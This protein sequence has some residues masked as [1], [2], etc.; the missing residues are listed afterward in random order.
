MFK[1]VLLVEDEALIALSEA[2]ILK[3]H[4]FE[5]E[6][7]YNGQQ[8]VDK[9][10]ADS[11]IT[12]VLMDIDLGQGMNGAE[13]AQEILRTQDIPIVFLT[14]HTEKEYVDRV[15]KITGYGYILKNSGEM[16]L[17]SSINMAY[18]LYAAHQGLKEQQS[19]NRTLIDSA[20]EGKAVLKSFLNQIPGAA[21]VKDAEN[22]IVFC[23]KLFASIL[24]DSPQNLE[25]KNISSAVPQATE[26]KYE[27]ENRAV[28]ESGRIIQAESEFP[29]NGE[30]TFWL[31]YKF[32][33][34]FGGRTMVGA[35]SIDLTAQKQMER[36][37]RTR[38]QHFR[39]IA[40]YTYA[41]EDWIGT[42]GE[43]IWV[44]PAVER[45]TG[46]TPEEC[47][48]MQNYPQSLIHPE[49]RSESLQEIHEGLAQETSCNDRELRCLC[50]D[51]STK[52]ISVSWQPIY[53]DEGRHIGTRSSMR[54]ITENKATEEELNRTLQQKE[55]LLR[56]LNHRVKNNLTMVSSLLSLKDSALGDSV[57][58]SDLK[59]RID[60][61][62]LI[63]EKLNYT[64]NYSTVELRGY[65]QDILES[66]FSSFTSQAVDIQNKVEELN[67]STKTAIPLGLITNEIATNAMKYGFH[68]GLPAVFTVEFYLQEAENSYTLRLKNS[69]TP[70]PA[71]IDINSSETLGLKL[72]STLVLQLDGEI[73]ITRSPHPVFTIH[74]PIKP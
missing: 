47:Y 74:F 9:V 43:L 32:P 68:P 15:D 24:K 29:I 69:G 64:D 39:A 27:K 58:L 11:Q 8:A 44:N 16:V 36:K 33:L 45:I 49:D 71:E 2:Q 65:L 25:G 61:I 18:K 54:D 3:K 21:Y 26:T 17:V 23:N 51:G 14:S 70:F 31:T 7:A 22:R 48:R 4:G 46:Y 13:A 72:V 55:V 67:I 57:D 20:E 12:L 50:K 38:E 59:Y 63:H 66:I 41:W 34:E 53:D 35:I 60:T 28:I 52:W 1:K 40:D 5:V 19:H 73:H 37:L 62:R 6:I 30:N 10:R 42:K 56:E